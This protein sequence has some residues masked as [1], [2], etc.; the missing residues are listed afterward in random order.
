[1]KKNIVPQRKKKMEKVESADTTSNHG[2]ILVKNKIRSRKYQNPQ[3]KKLDVF[4]SIGMFQEVTSSTV[5]TTTYRPVSPRVTFTY[6]ISVKAKKR[7]YV[8]R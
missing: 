2:G 3:R 6:K 8:D 7:S 4:E 5:N 1:M